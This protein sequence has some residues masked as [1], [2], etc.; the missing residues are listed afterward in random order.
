M[1]RF[2]PLLRFSDI[3][4]SIRGID[5]ESIGLSGYDLH[6]TR[7]SAESLALLCHYVQQRNKRKVVICLPAYFCGQSLRF[8]RGT[9]VTLVFYPLTVDLLP[10]YDRLERDK[11]SPNFDIFVHVHFFGRVSEVTESAN[12]AKSKQ[13]VLVEDAAHCAEPKV[14]QWQGDFI[15]MS[16]HKHFGVQRSGLLFAQKEIQITPQQLW[17]SDAYT[18]FD[19]LWL[20]KQVIKKVGLRSRIS[21]YSIAVCSKSEMP[22]CPMLSKLASTFIACAMLRLNEASYRRR[23]NLKVLERVLCEV[24]YWRP[25][26]QFSGEDV[27]F[28]LGMLC[29]TADI[30]SHRYEILNR[31]YPLVQLWPDLPAE[32]IQA[33]DYA[34]ETCDLVSR[35][36]FFTLHQDLEHS[37]WINYVSEI[38]VSR[39][40]RILA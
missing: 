40:F 33:G 6:W 35:T 2:S 15:L 13:A 25:L 37:K 5:G 16:P 12:F 17:P 32:M 18:G 38:M 1:I 7:G 20:I 24:D 30:A 9:D 34:E 8:L 39:E 23:T 26:V 10:D 14:A 29:D 36:L 11:N 27:P 4:H 28:L 19:Y 31:H 3:F 21:P 22:R